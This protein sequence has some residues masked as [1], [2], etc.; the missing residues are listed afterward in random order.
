MLAS[1]C[2][3]MKVAHLKTMLAKICSTPGIRG[4][5]LNFIDG[6][7]LVRVKEKAC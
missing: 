1:S 2:N 3:S 5:F 4:V 7:K 6:N